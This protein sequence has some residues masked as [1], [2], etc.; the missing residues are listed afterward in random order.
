MTLGDFLRVAAEDRSPWNCSTMAADWCIAL[1]HP[2]FAAAWRG[3]TA[4]ADCEAAPAD[5][6]GLVILW[7]RDIGEALPEA[8][9]PFE[10]GDIGVIAAHGFEAGA[11]FT[12]AKWA[13]KT[14]RGLSLAT[15]PDHCIAKAWRP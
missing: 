6:G 5:V 4:P 8:V 7:D 14:P 9:A 12:G 15:L 13:V 3:V 2:D 1:G 10:A 11:I